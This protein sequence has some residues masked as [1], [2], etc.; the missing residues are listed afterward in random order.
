MGAH[1]VA[2][3]KRTWPSAAITQMIHEAVSELT[4]QERVIIGWFVDQMNDL[5]G[6]KQDIDNGMPIGEQFGTS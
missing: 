1:Q 2:E 6:A 3:R 4:E 5:V